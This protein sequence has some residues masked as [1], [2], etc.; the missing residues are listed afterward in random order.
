LIIAQILDGKS[1]LFLLSFG[2]KC[3]NVLAES[4]TT[5]AYA[6][7]DE[8]VTAPY[9]LFFPL[10]RMIERSRTPTA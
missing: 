9:F 2:K 5:T 10:L 8:K 7:R 6:S 1:A 3:W 4:S